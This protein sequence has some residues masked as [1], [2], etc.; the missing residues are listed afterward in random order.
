MILFSVKWVTFINYPKKINVIMYIHILVVVEE[1]SLGLG[2]EE[3]RFLTSFRGSE[4]CNNCV[5][6]EGVKMCHLA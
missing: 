6:E 4:I 3:Q 1:I 5:T 2:E